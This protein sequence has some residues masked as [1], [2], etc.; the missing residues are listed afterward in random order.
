M[1]KGDK[2]TLYFDAFGVTSTEELT[3][4]NVSREGITFKYHYFN[5]GDREEDYL[6]STDTGKCLNQPKTY[7][8][9][10]RRIKV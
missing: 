10:Q 9:G 1:K 4:K 6:Y 3:V 5:A 2:V 8:G 7:F